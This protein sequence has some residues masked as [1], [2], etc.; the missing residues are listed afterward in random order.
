[1]EA[2]MTEED[3]AWLLFDEEEA[4]TFTS[5]FRANFADPV[6]QVEVDMGN[7]MP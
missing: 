7:G 2:V 5:T 3:P 4:S 6:G 1:M